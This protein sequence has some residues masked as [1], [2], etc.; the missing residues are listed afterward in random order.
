MFVSFT[1]V[2]CAPARTDTTAAADAL[3]SM[4]SLLRMPIQSTARALLTAY[5]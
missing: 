1:A 4:P 5:Y 3:V 2:A